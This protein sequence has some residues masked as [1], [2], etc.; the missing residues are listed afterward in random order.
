M[1]EG[2]QTCFWGG[3]KKL[4]FISIGTVESKIVKWHSSSEYCS[5]QI[6]SMD[7]CTNLLYLP[8]SVAG[9]V[10]WYVKCWIRI[11]RWWLWSIICSESFW[12]WLP[13]SS[14][15]GSMF[16]ISS[17]FLQL[18]LIFPALLVSQTAFV[19]LCPCAHGT[20]QHIDFLYLF[21]P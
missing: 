19:G 3:G 6:A 4:L 20:F 1:C 2:N 21:L 9:H 11:W 12:L 7:S 13:D 18:N 5:K 14:S 17:L 15:W 16:I 8:L 10:K